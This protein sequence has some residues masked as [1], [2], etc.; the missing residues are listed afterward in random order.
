[1]VV[2]FTNC[3]RQAMPVLNRD[4]KT[5]IK[6]KERSFEKFRTAK[7]SH[8]RDSKTAEG[9]W[10]LN[11]DTS[12]D[13]SGKRVDEINKAAGRHRKGN[14]KATWEKRK[15]TKK[16]IV[17]YKNTLGFCKV[18]VITTAYTPYETEKGW[19]RIISFRKIDNMPNKSGNIDIIRAISL[20]TCESN[21]YNF[22]CF[23]FWSWKDFVYEP[24]LK[25]RS[26][27][28]F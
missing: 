19:C 11:Q 12:Q 5:M 13:I 25:D 3:Q 8:R 16:A 2:V 10:N 21:K 14:L 9:N 7:R 24:P 4:Q 28:K 17:S 23:V 18:D 20:V 27:W 26:K 22:R 1:M 15:T 6:R